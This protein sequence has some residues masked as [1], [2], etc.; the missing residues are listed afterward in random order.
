M[1]SAEKKNKQNTIEFENFAKIIVLGN[2]FP[3][4][5]DITPSFWERLLVVPF[6]NMF[7]KNANPNLTHEITI[8]EN[9]KSGILNFMIDGLKLLLEEK[10]FGESKSTDD[11]KR[12]FEKLSDTIIAFF[13]EQ[14]IKNPQSII[15][16]ETIY[17]AYKAYCEDQGLTIEGKTKFSQRIAEQPGVKEDRQQIEGKTTRCWRGITVKETQGTKIAAITPTLGPCA[18][19]GETQMLSFKDTKGNYIC[20]KCKRET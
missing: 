10:G 5:R 3:Q 11:I 2:R 6:P 13:N 8:D 1:V 18:Y 7:I 4:V 17:N 15:A 16:K 19:C 14:C 20:D 12:E 9:E